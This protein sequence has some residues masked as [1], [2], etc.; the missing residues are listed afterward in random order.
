MPRRRITHPRTPA[1]DTPEDRP[2][3]PEDALPELAA[4]VSRP[5]HAHL[6]KAGL[7]RLA[8]QLPR[9]IAMVLRWSWQASR[10]DT[11]AM[12]ACNAATGLLT[13]AVLSG[14]AGILQELLAAG[15]TP[16]RVRA[17]APLL[18]L[19]AAA[20]IARGGLRNAGAW[21]QARLEPLVRA[22]IEQRLFA[23]TSQVRLE[24]YDESA[25]SDA[26][27]RARD[28]G[29]NEA[30]YL[31]RFGVDVVSYAIGLIAIAGVVTVLHPL[32]LPLLLLSVVPIAWAGAR[33][34]QMRYRR[35]RE[36]STL[37]RRQSILAEYL[38]ERASAAELRSYTMEQGLLARY[39]RL[40]DY[41][42]TEL[43]IV[44]GRQ[45]AV[46][47]AGDAASGLAAGLTLITL[48]A[49]LAL[50][51]MPLAVAGAAY[52]ALQQARTALSQLI[53]A[54]T[55]TYESGLYVADI[56]EVFTAAAKRLPPPPTADAPKELQR[57]E[58]DDVTFAYPGEAR[59]ALDGVSLSVQRGE[60][61]ALV[62]ENGSGKS[63]LS[64]L[65]A[66]LYTP[67]SGRICWNGTDV[68][69]ID[70]AALRARIALI[71]QHYTQWPFSARDNITMDPEGEPDADRLQRA[72][73]LSGA[74]EVIAQLPAGLD[75]LLDKRFA[76]G[77]DLSQG[78]RQR[79]AAARGLY[80]D[81]DL[82]IADEPTAALDARA[83]ALVFATLREASRGR[84]VLLI[85]HR[86][87]SVRM[88]DRIIVLERGRVAEQGT[89]AE[90]I[91]AGG[92]Y[93]ELY[94]IQ[95]AAYTAPP[96]APPLAPAPHREEQS[97]AD[98]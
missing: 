42:R 33:S 92:L 37:R 39:G 87:A 97:A 66:G 58:I 68:A 25:F 16:E 40:L 22:V 61:V 86:L 24:S 49:L 74:D 57:L 38:A 80:R 52:I 98:T 63:T 30:G 70:P 17:A 85:T 5:W 2:P 36:L 43:L 55:D 53:T 71:A 82:L 28:R 81:G 10:R 65:I 46:R 72:L 1:P 62:G 27:Y 88:A 9:L 21:F 59:P 29:L 14:V 79:I 83:E 19:I 34:A 94:G 15:P 78:Q 56:E 47:T 95:A 67:Q 84:T 11:V 23:L 8:G 26:I 45:T 50:G 6:E 73:E 3:V 31:L 64:R 35:I 91:G 32:L 41:V 60:I 48:G 69:A 75:T 18:A 12:V 7:L 93:A 54:V 89:H 13:A 20:T 90:L 96:A 77:A 76:N 4:S 51:A 44:A